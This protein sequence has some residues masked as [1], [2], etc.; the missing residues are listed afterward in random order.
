MVQ[1]MTLSVSRLASIVDERIWKWS[2]GGVTRR[3][4]GKKPH[5]ENVLDLEPFRPKQVFNG[6]ILI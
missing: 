4:G 3:G 5:S 2:I 6:M 1:F